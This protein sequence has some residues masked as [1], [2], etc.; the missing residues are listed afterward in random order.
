M[1]AEQQLL[2]QSMGRDCNHLPSSSPPSSRALNHHEQKLLV[3]TWPESAPLINALVHPG[4][5]WKLRKRKRKISLQSIRF[6]RPVVCQSWYGQRRV[7][8]RRK[9]RQMGYPARVGFWWV[10]FKS[11]LEKTQTIFFTTYNQ[12]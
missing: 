12:A 1:Y 10:F 11:K 2:Q 7:L 3:Q 5:N 8:A 9:S 4:A 6:A